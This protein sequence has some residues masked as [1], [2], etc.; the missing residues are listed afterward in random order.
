VASL[1]VA[2]PVLGS[3]PAAQRQPAA[4][5]HSTLHWG[6]CP[7]R[8]YPDLAGGEEQCAKLV[9]PLDYNRPHNGKTVTLEVSILRH[10][11]SAKNYRGVVLSNPGGPGDGGLDLPID[12]APYVPHGV[13]NDFDWVSW[14]PRG[15]GA[16]TPTIRCL[17]NYFHGHRGSYIPHTKHLLHYWLKRSKRYA[18]ACER[19]YP[20]LLNH[21]TSEDSARDMESIRKA[22]GVNKID[23]YGYSY[24]SY[25]GEVYSTL[26]PQHLHRMVLDSNVDPRR[27]WYQANLDQDR[28][29]DRNI[30]LYF[31][32]V[33][34][35][36]D[37][38][39][40]GATKKAVYHRYYADLA[41]LTRHPRGA[42]GPD[43]WQDVIEGA[44]Y[45]RLDFKQIAYAWSR[46]DNHDSPRQ[47]ISQFR[48]TDTPGDDNGF[49]VYNAVQCTDTKWPTKWS[50]WARDNHAYYKK[51]PFLTWSNAWYNAPCLYWKGQVHKP[52]RINGARTGSVLLI[53][54][55]LDA[56]TPFEGSLEVRRLYPNSSLIAEPGGATH[57]DSLFGDSCVDN[58]IASYLKTGRRPLR[59]HWNGPD[60][61]CRPLPDPRASKA[62]PFFRRALLRKT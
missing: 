9:V 18:N 44:A 24:G 33:A 37:V 1:G 55:T 47:M 61:L 51:Y 10:T 28:A 29:F 50:R 57:A 34:K 40:L 49:A 53:D 52:V 8:I 60:A 27:V 25:L 2:E 4:P 54:E 16:S 56:A 30:R 38:Y 7:T 3:T 32:W 39:H 26:F 21:I 20:A 13:G 43:E 42:L 14:D 35:F 45:Y 59:K 48:Q 12:L 5:L 17:P 19:K 23:F 15:V 46:F 41:K 11:S 22:L 6:G 36:H 62:N 58:Q 31:K